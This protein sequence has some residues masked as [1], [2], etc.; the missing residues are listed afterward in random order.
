MNR[1]NF[2]SHFSTNITYCTVNF[3]ILNE[4]TFAFT[5]KDAAIDVAKSGILPIL[6]QALQRKSSLSCQVALVVAEMAREGRTLEY[7]KTGCAS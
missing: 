5:E 7:Y 3:I 6:A 2:L 1:I 4:Q